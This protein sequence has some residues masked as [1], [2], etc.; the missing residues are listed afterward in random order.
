MRLRL[1]FLVSLLL[2]GVRCVSQEVFVDF[3]GSEVF[4]QKDNSQIMV[5]LSTAS[6][7]QC[8]IELH[9]FLKKQNVFERQD[10]NFVVLCFLDEKQIKD[11]VVRK[12]LYEVAR[13][14][15]PETEQVYFVAMRSMKKIKF[16][17]YKLDAR[18]FPC[19][20]ILGKDGKT[21]FFEDYRK[22][23]SEYI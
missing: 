20:F 1:F 12:N 23:I 16:R 11:I 6:C 4:L 22:F 13:N 18:K 10:L 15:F 14:Y 8:Y 9:D 7:H 21:K 2:F 5:C 19:V 17:K 3:K